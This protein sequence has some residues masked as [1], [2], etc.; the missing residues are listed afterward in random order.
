MI[1]SLSSSRDRGHC[2][3]T[4]HEMTQHCESLPLIP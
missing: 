3:D 4:A 1:T 2:D